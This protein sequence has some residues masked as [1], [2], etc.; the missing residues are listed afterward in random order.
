[1]EIKKKTKKE[2]LPSGILFFLISDI[3]VDAIEQ[4]YAA[5]RHHYNK[6]KKRIG[7]L[8]QLKWHHR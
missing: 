4:L 3:S 6:Q 1:M 5:S 8:L 2:V 7:H